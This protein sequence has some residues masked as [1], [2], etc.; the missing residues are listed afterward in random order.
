MV[1]LLLLPLPQLLG[2]SYSL[3]VPKGLHNF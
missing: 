2:T 1:L 3:D